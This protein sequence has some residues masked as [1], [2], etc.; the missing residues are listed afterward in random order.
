MR[1]QPGVAAAGFGRLSGLRKALW[2]SKGGRQGDLR[3]CS[4]PFIA[5]PDEIRMVRD[6]PNLAYGLSGAAFRRF[7]AGDLGRAPLLN[8][9]SGSI[10]RVG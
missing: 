6:W 9:R 5:K 4:S 8:F 2:Y 10:P 1:D 3:V 7:R